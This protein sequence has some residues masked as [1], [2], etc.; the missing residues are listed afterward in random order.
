[1]GFLGSESSGWRPPGDGQGKCLG[2]IKLFCILIAV[3]VTCGVYVFLNSSDCT[4]NRN[5]LL[6]KL[7]VS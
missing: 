3:L 2:M 4:Q 6:Y 7:C 1:M 5:I